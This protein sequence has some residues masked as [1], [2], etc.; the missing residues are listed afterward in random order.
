MDNE[1]IITNKD[2]LINPGDILVLISDR[3]YEDGL[4]HLGASLPKQSKS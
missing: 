4:L 2:V 1:L 3:T